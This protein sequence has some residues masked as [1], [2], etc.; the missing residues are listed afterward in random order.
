MSWFLA[1]ALCVG[2]QSARA[3]IWPN[4]VERIERQ[5]QAAD[6]ASRREAATRLVELPPPV[7]RRLVPPALRDP[8]ADVRL[9]AVEAAVR[10]RLKSETDQVVAWLSATDRRLRLAAAGFLRAMPSTRAISGLGRVL[11]DPDP[12]VRIAAAE[13]LGASGSREAAMPLLAHLDDSMPDVQR[14]VIAALG[15]LGDRSAVVPLIGKVQHPRST[16]RLSVAQALGRLGDPRAASA[17]VLALRDDDDDVRVAALEALG[18]LRSNAAT[19]AIISVLRAGAAG[20]VRVAALE[21][22]ARIGSAEGLDA[23]LDA[24]GGEEPNGG[25]SDVRDA[26]VQMGDRAIPRLLACLV[27]QPAPA[28]ADGCALVLGA[29]EAK[30]AP[31]AVTEALRR[32][33]IRPPAALRALAAV[34]NPQSLPTALE[35]LAD[36][37]PQ[38]RRAAID[39]AAEL[40]DPTRPDG[41]AVDPIRRALDMARGSRAEQVA[42]IS[43]LGRTGSPRAAMLLIPIAREADSAALRIA[44]IEALGMVGPAGQDSALLQALEAEQAGVRL[45]AAVA[46]RRCATGATARVLLDR[47]EFA[48]EQDRAATAIALAGALSRSRSRESLTRAL[49][50]MLTSRGAE[51]DALIEAIGQV[52]GAEATRRLAAHAAGAASLADRAKVAEALAAHPEA[53]SALLRLA[54]DVDGSVR[55]NAVWSLGAVATASQVARVAAALRD[56]DVAVAGNAAAALGRIGARSRASVRPQL[57]EALQDPRAYVRANALLGLAVAGER[58]HA[59][60]ARDLLRNDPAPIVRRAAARLLKLVPDSSTDEDGAALRACSEEE[61]HGSVAAVCDG[62]PPEVPNGTEPVLVYVVPLGATSPIARAP[63]ALV[64][65]DGLM[66]LGI[67]DRRGMLLEHDAPRGEIWLE[68]PAPLAL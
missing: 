55:A 66:R 7:A 40:L 45:A 61:P 25:T 6:P 51:R 56:R 28:L 48:A 32:G 47:L 26:L 33:V 38:V 18:G 8:D 30:Q 16:V 46:L 58:C 1:L 3:F 17:L 54:T 41:R 15:R 2:G 49:R 4:T 53:T 22:L 50:L 63:F 19:L 11:G 39:A 24:L 65:A 23:L 60:L 59:G 31:A 57:C 44:A 13:A 9:A 64:R 10:L 37:E 29:L 52:P 68:V 12:Q 5:L 20:E 21:A 42:L 36:P 67:T 34:G 27:G 35:Y 14:A 62:D 43:L